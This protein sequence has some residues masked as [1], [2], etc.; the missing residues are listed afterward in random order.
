[1]I[2]LCPFPCYIDSIQALR[3]IKTCVKQPL[4][5]RPK[6][7][8][9]T[10]YRLNGHRFFRMLPV[11][12]SAILSTFIKLPINIKIFVLSIISGRFTQFLLYIQLA[13]TA[14]PSHVMFHCFRTLINFTACF[15]IMP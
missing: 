13:T 3:H 6:M 7:V 10:N 1:M 8:F 11:E 14:K 15:S 9:K 5:K 4:S 2:C 12:H